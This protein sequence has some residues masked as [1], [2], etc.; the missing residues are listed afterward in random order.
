MPILKT[1]PTN[2]TLETFEFFLGGGQFKLCNQPTSFCII[3]KKENKK[4]Q[5]S[6]KLW[7]HTTEVLTLKEHVHNEILTSQN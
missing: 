7:Q 5:N 1:L 3:S 2:P 6:F 4:K